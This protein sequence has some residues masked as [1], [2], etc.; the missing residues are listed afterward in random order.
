[1]TTYNMVLEL[2][3]LL[4]EETTV[5]RPLLNRRNNDT[6]TTINLKEIFSLKGQGKKKEKFFSPNKKNLKEYKIMS[7][8]QK[9]Q[10]TFA[11]RY[12]SFISTFIP[13]PSHIDMSVVHYKKYENFRG[14]FSRKIIVFPNKIHLQGN[15]Y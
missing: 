7:P 5:L 11:L 3:A 8:K 1:M 6:M 9:F 2:E 10:H 12:D 15:K 4:T 13:P 14:K